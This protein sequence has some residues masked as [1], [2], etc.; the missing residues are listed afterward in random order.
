MPGNRSSHEMLEA[1][2]GHIRILVVGDLIFDQTITGSVG[3]IS[4]EAPIPVV[5]VESRCN[6]LG[7]A[8]N[9]AHNLSRLVCSGM[10]M[11]RQE[12]QKQ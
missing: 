11:R 9:V 1:G 5:K 7:G 10:P 2:L 3:R 8:G 4:P 12:M 6:G